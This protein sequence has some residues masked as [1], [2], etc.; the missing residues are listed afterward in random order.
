MTQVIE[1]RNINS[2]VK[3][4]L[5]NLLEKGLREDSRNGKVLVAE[6]PVITVYERPQERVLFSPTRDAN[7][8]FHLM[9]ALWMLAGRNDVAFPVQ[10]N[11]R[12]AEYSDDT[13]TI[14]GAYGFR[15]REFFGIDQLA[16]LIDELKTNPKTRR[17]V[18]G[19]W[20]PYADLAP[21]VDDDGNP[22]AGGLGS[23]DVPCNTHVYFDVRGGKLNMTVC[24][25]S[26]DAIWGAYGAN[27]VHFSML[28]EYIAN[29]VGVPLGVYRQFSNNF[30]AYTDIYN[31]EALAAIAKEA[32]ET[33][34]YNSQNTPIIPM[35]ADHELWDEAL[36]AFI[37]D[38][39][40]PLDLAPAFFTQVAV[41]M[42]AAWY[43]RKSKDESAAFKLINDMPDCDWKIAAAAWMLRHTKG[44]ANAA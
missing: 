7:P 36:H 31:E 35:G 26:N 21:L 25:R 41:P 9:E 3:W 42:R 14:H 32:G 19:M 24:C 34:Y 30:H 23:K 8:F 1:T 20:S 15:W 37:D 39:P 28:Q 10:F 33:N 17:A 18:L 5:T 40:L 13:V 29:K 11:K 27:V 4:G 2:A 16:F 6:D 43:A 22:F 12:F 38:V 44:Q